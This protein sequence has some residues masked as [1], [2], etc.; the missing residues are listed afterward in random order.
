MTQMNRLWLPAILVALLLLDPRSA[1]PLQGADQI[2]VVRNRPEAGPILAHRSLFDDPIWDDGR[3]ELSVYKGTIERYGKPRSLEATIIV[4]KEDMDV[5]QR[6]KSERGPIA[7]R[8]RTVLKQNTLRNFK[9]GTYEYHQMSSTFLDRSTGNLEKLVMSSTEG[10]GITFVE[11]LPQENA[12]RH[13]SHSYWDGEGDRER[14]IEHRPG[15]RMI[16][17]DALTL[18]LRRLDLGRPQWV[19]A[20]GLPSQI[21]VHVVEPKLVP[22][23]V[24]VVG[25]A[26]RYGF[27]VNV[28]WGGRPEERRIDRYWFDSAWPHT[29]TRFEGG[30][31]STV[32]ERVKTMRIAYWKKTAPGDERLL[33]P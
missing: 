1:A 27:P 32:L 24:E 9:T 13:V 26:D 18:W 8:T 16:A 11:V 10:C 6:V 15:R 28:E 20:H 29:L 14:L 5:P 30:A 21:S 3:A 2:R 7:G 33:Q 25:R 12:W 17:G 23:G 31:D 22:A 4:V 19:E